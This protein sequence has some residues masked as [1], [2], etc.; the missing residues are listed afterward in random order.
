MAPHAPA[1]FALSCLALIALVLICRSGNRSMTALK[2]ARAAGFTDVWHYK[3]GAI[4]W[5]HE[6]GAAV[7]RALYDGV[8]L[9][10]QVSGFPGG[11]QAQGDD[12]HRR[13]RRNLHS[14]QRFV[15]CPTERVC[16]LC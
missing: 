5:T 16:A 2:A 9:A 4:G 12:W 10:A 7:W 6:G 14:K 15:T 13:R 1:F 8:S 11:R 3:G